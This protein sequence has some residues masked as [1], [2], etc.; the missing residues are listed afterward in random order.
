MNNILSLKGEIKQLQLVTQQLEP[1]IKSFIM[2]INTSEL[3]SNAF[4]INDHKHIQILLDHLGRLKVQK[5][6]QP[7]TLAQ[8][9][10]FRHQR[11]QTTNDN[12]F[13]TKGRY[14]SKRV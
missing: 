3:N 13:Y 1:F 8:T 10:E 2:G 9:K 6:S 12:T 14:I 5:S 7:Q 4:D 11:N